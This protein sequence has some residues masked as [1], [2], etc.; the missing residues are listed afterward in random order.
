VRQVLRWQALVVILA[1][2]APIASA[3]DSTPK[4][5]F[6]AQSAD[7]VQK[8]QADCRTL[9]FDLLK[10]TDL[11][12]TRGDGGKPIPFDVKTLSTEDR[13]K[14]TWN[15]IEL[16]STSTRRIKA[17]LTIPK[18]DEKNSKEKFPA[19]VCIHGHGGHRKIVYDPRSLYRAFATKLA[20]EGYVTISTDVGQH[21]VYEDG[22]TL[23]GERLWDVLR[24]A[25][26]VASLPEVDADRLGCGGLS[27][28]GEMA[29]WLGAMDPRMKATVSSGYLTTVANLKDRH[30]P[31]WDFPGFTENFE[32]SDIY[33]LIAP[34][35]LQ[36]QIGEKERAPGGFPQ[37]IA[38]KAQK[39]IDKAYA[40]AGAAGKATLEIHPEGH[41]YIVPTGHEFFEK[42]LAK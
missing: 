32:F 35:A 10:L 22:R 38:R 33:S 40:V 24:C 20:E 25:D 42:Y 6:S 29:M 1:L 13:G 16:N 23:M 18:S 12:A 21:E 41:V 34:R 7:E 2:V 30:C 11:Q 26:Y 3:A 5:H 4:R 31:C 37:D 17:I 27:L 28:G 14:Y 15:E 36:C 39:E 9:L 19:V 8:W